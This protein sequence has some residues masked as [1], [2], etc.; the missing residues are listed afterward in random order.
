MIITEKMEDAGD[1]IIWNNLTVTVRQKRDFFT[2]IYNKFQRREYE[3]T[4]TILKGG[5]ISY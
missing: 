5:N 3:E 4:L 2:N 1:M